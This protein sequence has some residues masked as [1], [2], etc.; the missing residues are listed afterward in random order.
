MVVSIFGVLHQT[1]FDGYFL[2]CGFDSEVIHRTRIVIRRATTKLESKFECC[3]TMF[4]MIPFIVNTLVGNGNK[5]IIQQSCKLGPWREKS[6][7]VWVLGFCVACLLL[8]RAICPCEK[9]Y[10][11]TL[12]KPPHQNECFG[13]DEKQCVFVCIVCVLCVL[14]PRHFV[15]SLSSVPIR[16]KCA[17]NIMFKAQHTF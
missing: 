11:L 12:D 10:A 14:D 8:L 5:L 16:L 15:H 13:M 9:D 7:C 1:Q 17:Q 2:L 4:N 6:I 3:R